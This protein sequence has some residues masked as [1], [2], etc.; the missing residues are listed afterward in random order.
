M[1][2]K[3]AFL[4]R[5]GDYAQRIGAP[6]A[7]QPFALTAKGHEQAKAAGQD[8]AKTLK[9]ND[10]HLSPTVHCS[11]Q[12][13]AWQTA[14]GIVDS[15][16]ENCGISCE[17]IE[18]EALAER[19]VGALANLTT[20]DI[21]Q[22]IAND[23][24]HDALPEGWKSNSHFKLPMQGAESLM[25]A[26]KRVA[27]YLTA[28]MTTLPASEQ[29]QALLFVGHGASFRHAAHVLGVLDYDDID[30]LSMHH[31]RPIVLEHHPDETWTHIGGDWKSRRQ[32]E[33]PAD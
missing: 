21:E 6:S 28:H 20:D 24:R 19:S 25:E 32:N 22:V 1:T 18:D 27:A 23:P 9:S 5:H 3:L 30:R 31:A 16:V 14:R 7:L 26:G 4:I 17:L 15:L 12:L 10:W 11:R 2:R 8:I 33:T 29:T 13:R